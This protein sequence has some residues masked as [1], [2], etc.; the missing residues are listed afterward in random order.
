LFAAMPS[1]HA[2][3]ESG[4]FQLRNSRE[5]IDRAEDALLAVLT[6]R[7][8][9]DAAKFAVRLALEEGIVNA[10]KHGHKNLPATT[11]ITFSFQVDDQFTR[12]DIIDQGPGFDPASVPDPT[13]EENLGKPSGR[14]LLLMRAYMSGMEHLGRGNHL[15]L[16]FSKQKKG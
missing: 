7:A 11:P 2:H 9:P 16:T 1:K 15:R 13:L 4:S 5:E 14:G 12:I 6:T 3:A 10:F 8:Y